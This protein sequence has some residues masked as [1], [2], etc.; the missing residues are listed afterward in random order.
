MIINDDIYDMAHPNKWKWTCNQKS[1]FL[2]GHFTIKNNGENMR[3]RFSGQ[4]GCA[5]KPSQWWD[6]CLGAH[7]FRVSC[8]SLSSTFQDYA[9]LCIQELLQTLKP[10]QKMT[11]YTDSIRAE[12]AN[13]EASDQWGE[14]FQHW[15]DQ[16]LPRAWHIHI[17]LWSPKIVKPGESKQLVSSWFKKYV[18]GPQIDGKKKKNYLQQK[19]IVIQCR[20]L[21]TLWYVIPIPDFIPSI[22]VRPFG[23]QLSSPGFWERQMRHHLIPNL[24]SEEIAGRSPIPESGWKI[25]KLLSDWDGYPQKRWKPLEKNTNKNKITI[26]TH[27]KNITMEPW[28][29][30]H[31]V[32][33]NEQQRPCWFWSWYWNSHLSVWCIRSSIRK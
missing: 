26:N 23:L 18:Y 16:I 20:K 13:C 32:I 19:I 31:E 3:K 14:F 11:P 4:H 7:W 2:N 5:A 25:P 8:S 1:P 12:A 29:D 24:L 9:W 28:S 30:G 33:R 15:N 6:S 21:T 10:Q 17:C 22:H 27:L